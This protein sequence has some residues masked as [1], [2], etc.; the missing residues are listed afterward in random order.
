MS[1][2]AV[3]SDF[4]GVLVRTFDWSG[5]ALW[6]DRLRLPRGALP[7]L[8]FESEVSMRAMRG[9]ATEEEVWEDVARR[10]HLTPDE[11][12][13][14]RHDF[15][16]GDRLD[17]ELLRFFAALRPRYRTAILSNAWN[18]VRQM[19]GRLGLDRA[20]ELF[21]ISAEEGIAKPD[22]SIYRLAAARLG[23][24]P[25][26][27]VLIDDLPANVAGARAAGMHA[28]H[29]QGPEQAIA[30]LEQLL[31]ICQGDSPVV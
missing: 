29:F 14:F 8:V 7:G 11:L 6:E 24:R 10:F 15:W 22:P 4:G 19:F 18:G 1:I 31:G 26:E 20:F 27:A 5:R 13:A 16:R 25:E 17:E 23:V 2:R 9:Q 30:A 28:V 12:R 21:I 3:I